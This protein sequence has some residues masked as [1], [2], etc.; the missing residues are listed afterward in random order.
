MALNEEQQFNELID[1]S[2]NILICFA[3]EFSGDAVAS[4]LALAKYL[5]AEDKKID[6]VCTD[7]K[8]PQE[9]SFLKNIN[10]IADKLVNLRQLV[11]ELDLEDKK[12]DEFSYDVVDDKLKIFVLPEQGEF[13]EQ[14]IQ[15]SNTD[16]KYDCVIT[17]GASDL[18]SLGDVYFQNIEF[19]YKTP[20]INIDAN[21]NN[22]NYGQLNL[23]QP[24]KTSVAEILFEFF[25][26]EL[27]DEKMATDLLTGIIFQTKSFKTSN[28]T[29]H[30]LEIASQ[31][32]NLGAEQEKIM[33]NLYRT[34]T[35]SRLKL[36]GRVLARMQD[37]SKLK[38]VWSVLPQN[39]F[40]KAGAEEKDVQGV[41]EELIV[42]SPQADIVLLLYETQSDKIQGRLYTAP[43]IDSKYLLNNLNIQGNKNFVTFSLKDKSLQQA[44]KEVI[45][46]IRQKLE[47]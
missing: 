38:L 46:E 39:D 36:W 3:K 1:Q 8:S 43:Q 6:I 15:S 44:E 13:H 29:P 31:L 40:I 2:K 28:V 32:I 16:Y 45:L 12:V 25:D 17:L 26:K 4:A 41:V 20:L 37:D 30:T 21:L 23:V 18:E 10:S 19:F 14:D 24:T 5:T 33:Q 35:L 7:F 27:I 22:E 9:F 42:N 47:R 11:I 34:K